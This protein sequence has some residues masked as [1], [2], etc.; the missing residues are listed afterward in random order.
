MYLSIL[1]EHIKSKR[2]SRIIDKEIGDGFR[3]SISHKVSDSAALI[4]AKVRFSG[5][6]LSLYSFDQNY[7]K[8]ALEGIEKWKCRSVET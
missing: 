4:Y 5:F 2:D 1:Q 7:A 8:I 6:Y 3:K